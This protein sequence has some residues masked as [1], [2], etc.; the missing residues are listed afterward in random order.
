MPQPVRHS[1]DRFAQRPEYRSQLTVVA[2]LRLEVDDPL[3]QQV[4]LGREGPGARRLQRT[5]DERPGERPRAQRCQAQDGDD[6]QA[7]G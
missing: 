1:S 3:A 7:G 4:A 6:E 2:C 5:L